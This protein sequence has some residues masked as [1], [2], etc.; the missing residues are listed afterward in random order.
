MKIKTKACK[1]TEQIVLGFLKAKKIKIRRGFITAK[2][3]VQILDIK[4][5][6]GMGRDEMDNLISQN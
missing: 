6:G 2:N 3:N 1:I 4:N 5:V